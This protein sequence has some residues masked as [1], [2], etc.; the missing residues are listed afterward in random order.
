MGNIKIFKLTG[1]LILAGLILL[2]DFFF[3][4]NN[5]ISKSQK[6][7]VLQGDFASATSTEV[8]KIN[9]ATVKAEVVDTPAAMEKGLGGRNGLNSGEG[10]WFIFPNEGKWG[11]WMKDMLFPI[12]IIWL[13]DWKS[14]ANAEWTQ[15]DAEKGSRLIVIGIKENAA[16]ESYPEIFYPP[17]NSSYVLE[18]P[19]GFAEKEKIKIGTQAEI[20][21]E[22]I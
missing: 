7:S 4:G 12:D 17:E 14:Q 20:F 19:S 3:W 11:I 21:S 1:L 13:N 16:P 22:G 15:T 18:V 10:M 9:G 8:I 6:N 2:T 5:S